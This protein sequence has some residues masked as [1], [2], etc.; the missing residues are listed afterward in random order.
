MLALFLIF[1]LVLLIMWSRLMH[2]AELN[3]R[4]GGHLNN[5]GETPDPAEGR[6]NL[7]DRDSCEPED[8]TRKG[9]GGHKSSKR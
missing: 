9:H 5:R 3:L 7:V 1:G 2:L 6:M 8:H 4:M